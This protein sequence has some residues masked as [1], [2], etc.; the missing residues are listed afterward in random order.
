M[1]LHTLIIIIF[2]GKVF[3]SLSQTNDTT[4]KYFFFQESIFI[5]CIN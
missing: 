3:L 1:I 5:Y 4:E 2:S